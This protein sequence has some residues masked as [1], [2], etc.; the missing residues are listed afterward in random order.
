MQQQWVF[1]TNVTAANYHNE[2][3]SGS[4]LPFCL[5]IIDHTQNYSIANKT[6]ITYMFQLRPVLCHAPNRLRQCHDLLCCQPATF[7]FAD[8][9]S[10]RLHS[11]MSL[12][13]RQRSANNDFSASYT[14]VILPDL[15]IIWWQWNKICL[16]ATIIDTRPPDDNPD[17]QPMRSRVSLL[18]FTLVSNN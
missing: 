5:I 17:S 10:V 9:P 15:S 7:I 2:I 6:G 14:A 3:I 13:F 8:A 4:S 1:L 11:I 18:T 16:R 12:Y